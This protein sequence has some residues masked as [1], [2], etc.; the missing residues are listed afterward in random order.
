MKGRLDFRRREA[1][2]QTA[3]VQ[4]GIRSPI[5]APLASGVALD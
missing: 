4:P 3:R 1:I 2:A 5:P